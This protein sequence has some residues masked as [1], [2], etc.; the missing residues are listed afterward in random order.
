[1]NALT[2]PGSGVPASAALTMV[3]TLA[4]AWEIDQDN[5][6]AALAAAVEVELAKNAG[7]AIVKVNVVAPEGR[8]RFTIE[9]YEGQSLA[10]IVEHGE[11]PEASL[12]GEYIECAC[13]G[14]MACS[15]CH[16]VVDPEW[17]DK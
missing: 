17:W 8:H 15:T 13:S 4:G 7:K 3:T 16:V 2:A 11:G 9:A 6:L 10:D 12:L 1:M 14:V 5:G